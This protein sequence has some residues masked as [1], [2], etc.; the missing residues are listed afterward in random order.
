MKKVKTLLPILF[1]C[2]VL[3]SC[4]KSVK[5]SG[6]TYALQIP[7]SEDEVLEV[8]VP[9]EMKVSVTD[10]ISYWEFTDGSKIISTN[11]TTHTTAIKDSET[12]LFMLSNGVIRDVNKE[13]ISW[14]VQREYLDTVKNYLASAKTVKISTKLDAGNEYDIGSYTDKKD[15][16]QLT[17]NGNYMPIDDKCQTK[18]LFKYTADL[19]SYD[20][21]FLVSWVQDGLYDEIKDQMITYCVAN[22]PKNC[23]DKWYRDDE[24]LYVKSGDNCMAMKKLTA[25]SWAVYVGTSNFE[26]YILTALK[27]IHFTK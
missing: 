22:S 17:E 3:V 12:G 26:D 19:I 13:S 6:N 11:S 20:G 15:V 24:I 1:I 27:V 16:M 23:V 21:K 18:P 2:L 25:N 5:L 7:V 10:N 4:G 14:T 9:E 8:S